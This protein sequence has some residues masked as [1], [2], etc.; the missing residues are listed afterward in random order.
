MC[1]HVFSLL[2]NPTRVG[3]YQSLVCNFLSFSVTDGSQPCHGS[4][5]AFYV[6]DRMAVT[7]RGKTAI[8]LPIA[9]LSK[10]PDPVRVQTR[11]D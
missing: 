6:L 10:R 8:G 5:H 11:E 4:R 7:E 2:N 9:L 3:N 1:E